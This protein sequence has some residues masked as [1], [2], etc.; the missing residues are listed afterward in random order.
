MFVVRETYV[1]MSAG[2]RSCPDIICYLLSCFPTAHVRKDKVR[3]PLQCTSAIKKPE[4]L[5]SP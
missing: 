2:K 1:V 4:I 5:S 3:I